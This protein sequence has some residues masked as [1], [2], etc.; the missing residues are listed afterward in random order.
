MTINDE[1]AGLLLESVDALRCFASL[2]LELKICL[3][4]VRCVAA[5]FAFGFRKYG[6]TITILVP[7]FVALQVRLCIDVQLSL[8]EKMC[9]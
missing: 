9:Q 8:M 5:T 4:G 7:Q 2:L 3:L 6:F 1:G